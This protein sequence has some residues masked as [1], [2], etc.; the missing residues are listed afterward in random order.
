MPK[1]MDAVL[2]ALEDLIAALRDQGDNAPAGAGEDFND[3]YGPDV[4]DD[5]QEAPARDNG[6]NDDTEITMRSGDLR[7]VVDAYR[8][9]SRMHRT[10]R[11]ATQDERNK[12]HKAIKAVRHLIRKPI[13]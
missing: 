3:D 10:G 6:I 2:N 13:R 9:L 1:N 12:L 4:D 7:K 11:I 8:T 5:V